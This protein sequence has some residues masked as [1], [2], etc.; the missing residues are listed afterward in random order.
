MAVGVS[1]ERKVN[2]VYL[3]WKSGDEC[4]WDVNPFCRRRTGWRW[5]AQ[6]IMC[7]GEGGTGCLYVQRRSAGKNGGE[8]GFMRHVKGIEG[9][10]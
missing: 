1:W 4:L 6:R 7:H 3:P 10:E 9:G 2:W 8:N 5:G